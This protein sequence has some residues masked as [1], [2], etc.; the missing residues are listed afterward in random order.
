MERLELRK[1]VSNPT[2]LQLLRKVVSGVEDLRRRI[3]VGRATV[4]N[5]LEDRNE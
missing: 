4:V 5:V 1:L 2:P 3:K